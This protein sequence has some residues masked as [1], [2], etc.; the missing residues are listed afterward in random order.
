MSNQFIN[1]EARHLQVGSKYYLEFIFNKT[2][3]RTL[4]ALVHSMS[5]DFVLVTWGLE[6]YFKI[7]FD[8]FSLVGF[9]LLPSDAKTRSWLSRP[10]FVLPN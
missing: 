6:S 4:H 2:D 8:D 3:Y 5:D 10:D 9:T 7:Y 1:D